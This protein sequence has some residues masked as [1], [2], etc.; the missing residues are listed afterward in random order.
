MK[1]KPS[2][3]PPDQYVEMGLWRQVMQVNQQICQEMEQLDKKLEENDCQENS[4]VHAYDYFCFLS[5]FFFV[6]LHCVYTVA[7]ILHQFGLFA[8]GLFNAFFSNLVLF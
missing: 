4:E 5:F 6:I 1:I 2:L 8:S 7:C 3:A